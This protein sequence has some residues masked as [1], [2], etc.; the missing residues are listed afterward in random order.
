MFSGKKTHSKFLRPI[1][2]VRPR[3]KAETSPEQLKEILTGTANAIM[4]PVRNAREGFRG[5]GWVPPKKLAGRI[6]L[7]V[8]FTR[9]EPD[10]GS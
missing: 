9:G 1:F 10:G 2:E 6:C 4:S 3:C 7:S 5:T 8:N